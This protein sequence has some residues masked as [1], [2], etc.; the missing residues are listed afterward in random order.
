MRLFERKKSAEPQPRTPRALAEMTWPSD[1]L[2]VSRQS[3][4]GL[5][6]VANAQAL[7]VGISSQL[8]VNRFRG[9]QEIERVQDL[10]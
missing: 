7:I 5:S 6:V 10:L 3:A 4:L 9:D 1:P 8:S 2:H